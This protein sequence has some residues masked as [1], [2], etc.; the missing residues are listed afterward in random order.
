MLFIMI[1]FPICSDTHSLQMICFFRVQNVTDQIYMAIKDMVSETGSRTLKHAD[2][3]ERCTQ[4]GFK[5]D[6]VD[7]C[8]EE[9]EELNVW[10][11]NKAHTKITFL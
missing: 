8:L 10:Q 4:K 1:P 7:A 11:V 3:M 5:P 2:V 9:Y 6:R